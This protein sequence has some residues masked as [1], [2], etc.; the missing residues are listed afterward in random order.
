MGI[1][2]VSVEELKSAAKRRKGR[3]FTDKEQSSSSKGNYDT[4]KGEGP[5]PQRSIDVSA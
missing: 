2:C 1:A 4:L 3:G 5:G